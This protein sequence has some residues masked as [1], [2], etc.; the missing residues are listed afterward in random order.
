M[1]KH[2]E[3]EDKTLFAKYVKHVANH[4]RYLAHWE[5]SSKK[6]H[7]IANAIFGFFRFIQII[8]N[9]TWQTK[10]LIHGICRVEYGQGFFVI[11]YL[12]NPFG[13]KG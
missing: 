11:E 13:S 4:I 2:V 1:K 10:M 12:W 6:P 7:V 5:P 8:W 9:G 3:V